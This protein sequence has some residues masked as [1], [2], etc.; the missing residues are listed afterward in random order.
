MSC[1]SSA[2]RPRSWAHHPVDRRI[3]NFS[4]STTAMM[5]TTYGAYV[6][7]KGAVEQLSHVLAK[8]LGPRGI[9][10]NVVSP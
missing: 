10:V 3:I 9:T 7:S 6:A 2:R 5:L 1:D 4:S 8:E